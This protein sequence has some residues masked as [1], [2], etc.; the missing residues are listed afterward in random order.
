VKDE[1]SIPTAEQLA[2]ARK[3]FLD[4]EPRQVFYRIA[5]EKVEDALKGQ[6]PYTLAEAI[7]LL[8][9]SWN[10]RYYRTHTIDEAYRRSVGAILEKYRDMV[11]R[12]RERSIDSFQ[13]EDE[14][15]L[16]AM[17]RDFGLVLGPV[18]P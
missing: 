4:L 15:Q 11:R 6:G 8:L 17:F 1:T 5:T 16:L 18:G 2:E 13:S 3:R 9:L 7:H 14:V 12:Y 10:F